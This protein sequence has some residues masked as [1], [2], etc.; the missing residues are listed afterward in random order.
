[1][2]RLVEVGAR[3][4]RNFPVDDCGDLGFFAV[5]HGAVHQVRQA[6]RETRR[7]PAQPKG[8]GGWLQ[9][10]TVESGCDGMS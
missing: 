4:T 7:R 6:V 9:S 5:V 3:V 10:E 2:T 8:G 1:M